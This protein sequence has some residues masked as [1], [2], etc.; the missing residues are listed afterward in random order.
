[1]TWLGKDML[2]QAQQPR[3]PANVL[4]DAVRH[5]REGVATPREQRLCWVL[6]DAHV[7]RPEGDTA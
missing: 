4:L 2:P 1:M 7:D 5:L 3:D 6:L